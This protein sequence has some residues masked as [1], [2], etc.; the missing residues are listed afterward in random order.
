MRRR[1]WPAVV[2]IG[3]LVLLCGPSSEAAE[4]HVLVLQS[5][6]SGN[7]TQDFFTG[8]FRA[9][10]DASESDLVTIMQFVVS[11][12]GSSQIPAE[13]I[14][15]FLRAAFAS[16]PTP[17]L[18][19]A[20]GGPAAVFARKFV[21]GLFPES[22]LLFAAVDQRFLDD[23]PLAGHEAAVAVLNDMPAIVD[24]ILRLFPRTS[25]VFMVIGSGPHDELWRTELTRAFKRFGDKV[26]FIWSNGLSLAEILRR[27]ATLPANSAIFYLM[28]GA[29]ASGGGHSEERVL[30]AIHGAANAPLFGSQG[31]MLGHGIVGGRLLSIDELGRAT[32]D[33]ALRIMN[34]ESPRTIRTPLLKPGPPI[35]DWRELQRWGISED[36]LPS[37]SVVRFRESS[38][39]DRFRW[40]IIGGVSVVIGQALLIGALLVNRAKRRRAEKLLRNNVADL[41]T[42]RSALSHLSRRLMEAQ[43]QERARIARELHDDVS[44][45][46]T[47]LAIDLA[48]LR[49][50]LPPDAAAQEHAQSLHDALIAL[51]RD[52][53]EISHR[54]HSSK[55][56]LMGLAAAADHFCRD[57]SSHHDLKIEYLQADV[58]RQLPDGVAISVFRVLQEAVANA[59][60]HSGARH[61][62]VTLR[63]FADALNLEVIDDGCGFDTKAAAHGHG[64]GLISMQERLKLV[65]GNVVIESRVGAGTVVRASVPL[66]EA[67]TEHQA[68]PSSARVR[69]SMT[70]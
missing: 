43:E 27:V 51:G 58:P 64:L 48:Q 36:R 56:E 50:A 54:M 23:A 20:V 57:V 18:V 42:A 7:L 4:R 62:T 61:C 52:I 53:Q 3:C 25:T 10:V 16:R 40:I 65:R 32:A 33:V 55:I 34:G 8:S 2:C 70:V 15:E 24:D 63:G 12:S 47:F 46:M 30:A 26:N 45:R 29:D 6:N 9:A 13:A 68:I 17:D 5:L 35:F 39:W 19:M 1:L 49:A 66:P 11:P 14:V 60:K 69:P 37:G 21:P 44:Q 31:A 41:D 59:V 38:I 28:F 67:A 22:P